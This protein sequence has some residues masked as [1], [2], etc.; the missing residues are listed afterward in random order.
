M[1]KAKIAAFVCIILILILLSVIWFLGPCSR[2]TLSCSICGKR[3]VV[4]TWMRITYYSKEFE[5]NSSRW[6]KE[7]R[8]KSH[9]HDWKLVGMFR[10]TWRGKI[11]GSG[12]DDIYPLG[13]LQGAEMVV[14][15]NTFEELVEEYYLIHEDEAKKKDFIRHCEEITGID[16]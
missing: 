9:N 3:K 13:L 2:T 12:G 1:K 10:Q 6:Y 5:T 7:K 15:P 8:L 4:K 14:D 16:R 11:Y